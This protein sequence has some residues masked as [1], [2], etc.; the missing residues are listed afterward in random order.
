MSLKNFNNRTK[1]IKNNWVELSFWTEDN[2]DCYLLSFYNKVDFSLYVNDQPNI[3]VWKHFEPGLYNVQFVF[4]W[5][6][7]SILINL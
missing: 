2:H 1:I 5:F 7:L 3:K 4:L 6:N